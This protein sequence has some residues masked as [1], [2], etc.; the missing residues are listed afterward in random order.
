M[1]WA[2]ARGDREVRS[3]G[4]RGHVTYAP[5]EPALASR[6]G[7]TTPV[8]EAWRCLRCGSFVPGPPRGRGPA[9]HAP[10]V[11][12]GRLLRDAW[13]LRLLALDR[14]VRGGLLLALAGVLVYFDPRR[15]AVRD[16][17]ETDLPSF[18]SLVDELGIDPERGVARLVLELFEV[19]HERLVWITVGVAAYGL[20]L[21]VEGVGLWRMRRWGE[22]VAAV[23]TAFF[24]PFEVAGL[25]DHVSLLLLATFVVNL[26][27]VAYLVWTKRLFGVRGGYRAWREDRRQT[28]LLEV[29]QAA[30]ESAY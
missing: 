28:S 24:V 12:R 2:W 27:L 10:V 17:F 7:V 6:I 30:S 20:L 21:L 1:R 3:C 23:A 19:S 18:R 9:D 25:L 14:F 26:F 16:Y 13:V 11:L 15:D 29:E 5:D 22:Y 8:G 4:W